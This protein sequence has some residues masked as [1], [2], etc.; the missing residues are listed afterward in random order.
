MKEKS[1]I[2]E[3]NNNFFIKQYTLF[4]SCATFKLIIR[5][6]FCCFCSR[7]S[8]L[9]RSDALNVVSRSFF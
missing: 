5:Y 3:S 2:T 6:N 1:N 9:A 8:A 4:V 7:C